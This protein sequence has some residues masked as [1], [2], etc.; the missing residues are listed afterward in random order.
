MLSSVLGVNIRPKP[1]GKYQLLVCRG[2]SKGTLVTPFTLVLNSIICKGR[3]YVLIWKESSVCNPT[4]LLV[5]ALRL[6]LA[7]VLSVS[8]MMSLLEQI[9]GRSMT[10][11]IRRTNRH[12]KN[13]FSYTLLCVGSK[14]SRTLR[15]A[16]RCARKQSFKNKK[17][18]HVS[19]VNVPSSS[20][21]SS[22]A[23]H[24]DQL[25]SIHKDAG[26]RPSL[27]KSVSS[28]GKTNNMIRHQ[29]PPLNRTQS[30]KDK[31][32]IETAKFFGIAPSVPSLN[33]AELDEANVDVII[34]NGEEERKWQQRRFRHLNKQYC[35]KTEAVAEELQPKI[36]IDALTDLIGPGGLGVAAGTPLDV[37]SPGGVSIARSIDGRLAGRRTTIERRESVAQIALS[38]LSSILQGIAF[39]KP[40][41]RRVGELSSAKDQK[42]S[43]L[44]PTGTAS[45]CGTYKSIRERNALASN[46]S[47]PSSKLYTTMSYGIA[48]A[49]QTVRKISGF[50]SGSG[51][52]REKD[53]DEQSN[54]D[55]QNLGMNVDNKPPSTSS[56]ATTRRGHSP[57]AR[58]YFVPPTITKPKLRR[59]SGV[60]ETKF[61]S[62]DKVRANLGQI[63]GAT[64]P[65]TSLKVPQ[66]PSYLPLE[67]S[68]RHVTTKHK[69]SRMFVSSASVTNDDVFF[70][71]S[72]TT[73]PPP[74]P[75]R[76]S[77]QPLTGD[78]ERP[79]TNQLGRS[80]SACFIGALEEAEEYAPAA[81]KKA[82]LKTR[83]R[84]WGQGLTD[85]AS[86]SDALKHLEEGRAHAGGGTFH[87]F[88]LLVRQNGYDLDDGDQPSSSAH[89]DTSA[90][91]L[92]LLQHRAFVNEQQ[93][94]RRLPRP[95]FQEHT[96]K[97]AGPFSRF[98][99]W[100]SGSDSEGSAS[101]KSLIK[102]HFSTR[103]VGTLR[104]PGT[105][106]QPEEP[107]TRKKSLP[108]FGKFKRN[109]KLDPE[110]VRQL[111]DESCDYRP[112]F[113]YWITTVQIMV[114]LF[115]LYSYGIGTDFRNGLGVIERS[116]D[117]MASYLSV[118]RIVVW[119]PNNVWIGPRFADLV[120]AGA[121]YSPCMRRDPK[122]MSRY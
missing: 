79:V 40:R 50:L 111:K 116:G 96:E 39:R 69:Q 90:T 22:I 47:F 89:T 13:E 30:I 85:M 117:V 80:P 99:Q 106:G 77:T 81:T 107:Q 110:V 17:S 65:R 112:F 48:Q 3:I 37:P 44:I 43:S 55:R 94:R 54:S 38:T 120:H 20:S 29:R 33:E 41:Q 101:F 82:L 103:G 86:S 52:I 32:T 53:G 14:S 45:S 68:G 34:S 25:E 61:I 5:L 31:M 93:Q 76:D 28:P 64:L 105:I 84:S 72:P 60:E 122:F 27:Y 92:A 2:P 23:S 109:R 18:E 56:A 21:T 4:T 1:R 59:T 75:K 42:D 46:S 6:T 63:Q 114:M 95:V 118:V 35:I 15:D 66:R 88:P 71:L 113:S 104:R 87:G 36:G 97:S 108:I 70:D 78:N 51:T 100:I 62:G 7:F 16:G 74:P 115:T 91:R 19:V 119:E 73:R 98:L 58:P 67:G 102:F 11:S 9:L 12:K 49:D 57:S 8:A 10:S 24:K 83:S 26:V 121:K